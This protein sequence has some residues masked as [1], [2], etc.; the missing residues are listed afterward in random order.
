MASAADTRKTTGGSISWDVT[1]EDG[2]HK[3]VFLHN[4]LTGNRI[5][6]YD[7]KELYRSGWMFKLVGSV[8]FKIKV[9][10]R[11]H[12]GLITIKVQ[13]I[14]YEYQLTIDGKSLSRLQ[15]VAREISKTWRVNLDGTQHLIVLEKDV[16]DVWVDG[17][18]VNSTGEFVDDGTETSFIVAGKDAYIHT[19]SNG[20]ML[21]Q[22][23]YI[24]DVEYKASNESRS[25][26]ED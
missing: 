25:I 16:M 7:G 10:K 6:Q 22:T 26:D 2:K 23:L 13:G 11:I 1:L 24:N 5:V 14:S 18:I 9:N 21:T 19:A 12:S 4:T 17:E 20:T 3:I 8:R 15:D